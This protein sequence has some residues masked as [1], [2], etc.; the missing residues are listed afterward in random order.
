MGKTWKNINL[1][2]I[3]RKQKNQK[4][5]HTWW[6][7]TRRGENAIAA[8]FQFYVKFD[9]GDRFESLVAFVPKTPP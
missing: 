9:E 2:L 6:F 4:L 3:G 7:R 5:I 1:H 8:K